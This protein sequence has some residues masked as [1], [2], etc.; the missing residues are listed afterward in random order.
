M[1]GGGGRR[2]VV[3]IMWVVLCS[4][5]ALESLFAVVNMDGWTFGIRIV[6]VKVVVVTSSTQVVGWPSSLGWSTRWW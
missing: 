6:V 2:V 3:V 5:R 1:G 4:V